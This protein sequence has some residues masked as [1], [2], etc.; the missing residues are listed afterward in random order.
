MRAKINRIEKQVNF[1]ESNKD[2]VGCWSNYY[3]INEYDK[4]I[5]KSK[6]DNKNYLNE[7]LK[8]GNICV[9]SSFMI[10]ADI[11]KKYKYNEKYIYA[12][13]IELYMRLLEKN[14]LGCLKDYL[15]RYRIN[16]NTS[17]DKKLL[18]Y[19][20]SYITCLKYVLK[21]KN[22]KT[23]YYLLIRTII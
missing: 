17:V 16:K 15:I 11:L 22:L 2:Y 7:F 12:Q 6:I 20:N 19:F 23:I 3:Y 21:N 5:H 1:L 14:K 13:D 18:S 10:I 8:K 4:V 9:H